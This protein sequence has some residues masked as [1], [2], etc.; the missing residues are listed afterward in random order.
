MTCFHPG[1]VLALT[2]VSCATLHVPKDDEH[3]TAGT[4]G[5]IR[6]YWMGEHPPCAV[7]PLRAIVATSEDDLRR[8]AAAVGGNA[9][10]R[11]RSSISWPDRT[12]GNQGMLLSPVRTFTGV[13]VV[14][15]EH[16]HA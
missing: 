11:V 3:F 15:G 1:L 4:L 8:A 14:V 5:A 10:M 9:V 16:C 13:A 7:Q 12:R 6:T 2:T